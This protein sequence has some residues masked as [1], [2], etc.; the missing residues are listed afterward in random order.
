MIQAPRGDFD[1]PDGSVKE[2]ST[3]QPKEASAK[4][5]SPV[6]A[7]HRQGELVFLMVSFHTAR[8]DLAAEIRTLSSPQERRE[9][10][11]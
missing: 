6:T 4:D 8:Q 5:E 11:A 9:R 7:S 3:R 2:S 10:N 1:L